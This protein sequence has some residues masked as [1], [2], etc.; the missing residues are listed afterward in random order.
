MSAKRR[1]DSETTVHQVR[2][3]DVALERRAVL[4]AQRLGARKLELLAPRLRVSDL[5][6]SARPRADQVSAPG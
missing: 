4:R 3:A 5:V 6:A 1:F 2:D